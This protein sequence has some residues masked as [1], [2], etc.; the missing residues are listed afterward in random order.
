MKI[1]A[2]VMRSSTSSAEAEVHASKASQGG[3]GRR[4]R[5]VNKTRWCLTT[6]RRTSTTKRMKNSER[7]RWKLTNFETNVVRSN[8]EASR[9]SPRRFDEH[10][11]FQF[12][13]FHDITIET[14]PKTVTLKSFHL[15]GSLLS[16]VRSLESCLQLRECKLHFTSFPSGSCQRWRATYEIHFVV[17][18]VAVGCKYREFNL[19][20]RQ[21]NFWSSW[22]IVIKPAT[23]DACAN[24]GTWTN[25]KPLTCNVCV[26][27]QTCVI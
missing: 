16:K 7:R 5:R 12:L 20:C 26:N 18:L 22:E 27:V 24:N 21:S 9:F 14:A 19:T 23:T 13:Q 11:G 10:R 6:C 17:F 15:H 2:L 4:S 8:H 1:A 3:K 25:R